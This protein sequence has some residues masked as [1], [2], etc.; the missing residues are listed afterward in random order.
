MAGLDF[1]P[2][3]MRPRDMIA[4]VGHGMYTLTSDH[5]VKYTS[6][7]GDSKKLG[8]FNTRQEALA[9]AQEHHGSMSTAKSRRGSLML[10]DDYYDA[11]VKAGAADAP[12]AGT[13]PLKRFPRELGPAARMKP[14]SDAD[15]IA[16]R[17]PKPSKK[18][19]QWLTTLKALATGYSKVSGGGALKAANR[20]WRAPPYLGPDG[21]LGKFN[22]R[23]RKYR[24]YRKLLRRAMEA[25][26]APVGPA[27][28]PG[29]YLP[30]VHNPK[31]PVRPTPGIKPS[32]KVSKKTSVKKTYPTLAASVRP[33]T[34]SNDSPGVLDGG[35]AVE[36]SNSMKG[37]SM[38]T[39]FNDLFKSEL[40]PSD[41]VVGECPHC[42]EQITKGDL[43]KAHKGKGKTTHVSGPKHGKSSA[44]VRDHNPDGGTMRGGDGH[45]VH[46]SSRGVPGA[47]KHDEVRITGNSNKKV[48]KADRCS[49]D[50]SSDDS[51]GGDSMSKSDDQV[52]IR[53]SA[54]PAKRQTVTVRGTEFVHYVDDGS[55]ARIAKAIAEGAVGGTSPT[56]PLDLNNDLTRLLI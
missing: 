51:S 13:G 40:G 43:E 25:M 48:T 4:H 15:A 37:I 42:Q 32:S 33:S 14:V 2:H 35:G 19:M 20:G 47:K 30:G 16:A 38:S 44:H 49:D 45:G 36:L 3:K 10:L 18:S 6:S 55:D 8:K 34:S 52:P 21:R 29:V 23:G 26:T 1:K 22:R 17:K 5:S 31:S 28:P 50:S 41:D 9:H 12:A 24:K 54:S 39:N 46:T 27:K 53:S 11:V 7:G 56:Q